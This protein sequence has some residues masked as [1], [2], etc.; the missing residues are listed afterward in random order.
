MATITRFLA[1]VTAVL[2]GLPLLLTAVFQSLTTTGYDRG[3][4]C[5]LS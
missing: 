3:N 1:A 5:K 4:Q 2:T